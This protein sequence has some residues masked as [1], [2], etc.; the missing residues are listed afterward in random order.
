MG[1]RKLGRICKNE[2]FAKFLDQFFWA[3]RIE[4]LKVGPAGRWKLWLTERSLRRIFEQMM[5]PE[6]ERNAQ[7]LANAVLSQD[8]IDKVAQII[9][10]LDHRIQM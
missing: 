3:H 10:E 6:Y 4:G 2:N 7:D 9:E 5:L 1:K 8:G